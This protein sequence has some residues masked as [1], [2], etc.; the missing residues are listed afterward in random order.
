VLR[1]LRDKGLISQ[2][3]VDNL[4]S[5]KHS[6]FSVHA[7]VK[8]PDRE[9]AARLG[10][11]MIRCP[12]VLERMSLD[13]D[14]GEVYRTR[15]SRADQPEGPVARWDVYEL[16]ARV[17]DHLPAPN[18]QIVRYWG[19]YSNVATTDEPF[20]GRGHGR[21]DGVREV[22]LVGI[23]TGGATTCG[24]A[25]PAPH[26]TRLSWAALIRKVYEIDPLLCPFCGGKMKLIAF[27]TEHAAVA[28]ILRHIRMPAQQPEPLAHSHAPAGRAAV[29]V[30]S[31]PSPAGRVRCIRGHAQ[32]RRC[33][34]SRR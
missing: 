27:I 21:I 6:G 23:E 25:P 11:Y 16:I 29:R 18:Q 8:V 34:L 3:V 22:V 33:S 7:D 26:R 19:F 20:R 5:W 28:H 32:V 4:L 9:A 2:E 30:V 24:G 31:S 15:P 10:R 17:L 12:V 1:L 14:T 13:E